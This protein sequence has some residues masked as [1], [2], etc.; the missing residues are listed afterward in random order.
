MRVEPTNSR[1]T[2][3]SAG[4]R[5]VICTPRVITDCSP[6]P[7]VAD[8]HSALVLICPSNKTDIT[9]SSASNV[10]RN[11]G[12]SRELWNGVLCWD[13]QNHWVVGV[14]TWT[15]HSN[16]VVVCTESQ[17]KWKLTV[18]AVSE[19]CLTSTAVHIIH[20][21]WSTSTAIVSITMRNGPCSNTTIIQCQN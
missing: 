19:V 8:L 13:T 18:G 20:K 7:I 3:L 17:R 16:I 10:A 9:I 14:P 1:V 21:N 15:L 5:S 2:K 12:N 6:L 4:H 11:C